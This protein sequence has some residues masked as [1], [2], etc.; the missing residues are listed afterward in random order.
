MLSFIL[1][2]PLNFLL[3]IIVVPII[4]RRKPDFWYLLPLT[5]LLVFYQASGSFWYA[6]KLHLFIYGLF[7]LIFNRVLFCGHRLQELW[8]EGAERIEDFGEHTI[9][10]TND[11]DTWMTGFFSYLLLA[12][13][14]IHTPH[15][16]F[17]TADHAALP[18]IMAIIDRACKKMGIKHFETTRAKCFVSL[19]KG[20]INRIPFIRK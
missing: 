18:R 16:F 12:G 11:T 5:V 2:Q 4:R 9:L 8:S 3:K 15:H 10:S 13:F 1:L 20:I 7:G 6:F 17:P 19:S 14:N